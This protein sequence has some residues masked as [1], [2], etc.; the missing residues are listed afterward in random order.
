MYICRYPTSSSPSMEVEKK[1]QSVSPLTYGDSQSNPP[2]I[3]H[4]TSGVSAPHL[5]LKY[6]TAGLS[7]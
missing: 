4:Y 3:L 1:D 6:R 5:L 2:S 7:S